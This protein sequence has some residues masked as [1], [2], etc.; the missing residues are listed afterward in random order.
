MYR[1][2]II[3]AFF[4]GLSTFAQD[5]MD[6]KLA[7]DRFEYSIATWDD[8]YPPLN[9]PRVGSRGGDWGRI[10]IRF[11]LG[12][13]RADRR[14]DVWI[15]ELNVT[16]DIVLARGPEVRDRPRPNTSIR[17][18]RQVKYVN[19]LT[20][21]GG[22][23]HW[24]IIFIPPEIIKRFGDDLPDERILGKAT[25]M[26]G[27]RHIATVWFTGKT[28]TVQDNPPSREFQQYV[29]SEDPIPVKYGLFHRLETPWSYSGS[30]ND[31][32]MRILPAGVE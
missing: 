15:D 13:G 27:R 30:G 21:G 24:A 29:M 1:T 10:S 14:D 19:V 20:S 17:L 8:I 3:L 22:T 12:D 9:L 26:H 2:L 25:F 23:T 6:L 5:R 28:S 32:M 4:V 16:W 11:E 7:V 18:S 31:E